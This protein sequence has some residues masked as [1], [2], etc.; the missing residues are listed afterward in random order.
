MEIPIVAT[1][2][3]NTA[4]VTAWLARHDLAARVTASA[5]DVMDAPSLVLPGVGAFGAAIAGLHDLGLFEP[6]R[7]RL[8]ARRP[9]LCICLGM[10][11]LFEASEESPGV[12]GLGVARGLVRRLPPSVRVPHM[13]WNTVNPGASD[14]RIPAGVAYF[15]NSFAVT[16]SP[17]GWEF[18]ATTH[19]IR[20]AS[21]I[22]SGPVLACQFHP[23]LSSAYGDAVLRAWRAR[24][25]EGVPC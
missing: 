7:E 5:R 12:A 11:L 10:Q 13:G 14:G 8:A 22:M 15:A 25:R 4:S 21:A 3:A 6:L 20:F 1:G 2:T 9:T 19:G 24:A 18:A 23:E 16:E 17:D